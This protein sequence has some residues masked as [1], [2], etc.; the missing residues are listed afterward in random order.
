VVEAVLEWGVLVEEVL[1][2][3]E[4]LSLHQNQPGVLHVD[5]LELICEVVIEEAVDV[6]SSRH[7]HQPG[8]SQVCVRVLD[9]VELVEDVVV[10]LELLP[11]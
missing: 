2:T 1:V 5:V 9:L 6:L 11:L 3:T 7:P 8:V 10:V 4:V